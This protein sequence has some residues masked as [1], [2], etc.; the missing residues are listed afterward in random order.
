VTAAPRR[1]WWRPALLLAGLVLVALVLR[2]GPTA[3]LAAGGGDRDS[4]LDLLGFA[5]AGA[6][7]CAAGLPRQV[8]AYAA[9]LAFGA[10][11]G[12]ALALVAQLAGCA[13]DL[14]WARTLARDWVL[15]RLRGRLARA[16]R[17]LAANP[18]S[19]TLTLRLL[20]VGNNLVLNLLAGVSSVPAGRFLAASL[21]GYVPQTAVFALL[22]AGARPAHN[23]DIGL[24]AALF[25]A[26]AASGLLLLR[27]TRA[28]RAELLSATASDA[29][30]GESRPG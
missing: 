30:Y 14:F 10:W 3:I 2:A 28:G 15:R 20:P 1:P 21:V 7:L 18:F 25:L 11:G 23:A 12:G 29:R 27:R 19:A 13:L 17:L 6:V 5:A 26:S 9:G 8:V 22:G 4:P 16:D 24:G